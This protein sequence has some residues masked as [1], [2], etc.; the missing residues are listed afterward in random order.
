M[1]HSTKRIISTILV[2]GL[3]EPLIPPVIPPEWVYI[4]PMEWAPAEWPDQGVYELAEPEAI[5]P[6]RL[7]TLKQHRILN[8][9]I[10]LQARFEVLPGKGTVNDAVLAVVD[11]ALKQQEKQSG[12]RYTPQAHTVGAGLADR[13]CLQG[14]ST[15]PAE[16]LLNDP[17]L[18]PP[19]GVGTAVTCDVIAAYG[20]FFGQRLRTVV[21]DEDGIVSDTS[22]FIYVDLYTDEMFQPRDLWNESATTIVW[23]AVIELLRRQAGSLS[24]VPV[25]SQPDPEI[26]DA[27][28]AS[29]VLASDGSLTVTLPGGVTSAELQNL[30]LEPTEDP[31]TLALPPEV[32][33]AITTELGA[34]FVRAA[35]EALPFDGPPKQWAGTE[36][37]N[38]KLVPCVALTY[39]DGPSLNTPGLLDELAFRDVS[40]TFFVIGNRVQDLSDIVA[41]TAAEGH[42]VA[43]HS[44]S[45]PDLI[46]LKQKEVKKELTRTNDVIEEVTGVAPTIFRPPYGAVNDK[47]LKTAKMPAILWDVDTNDWKEDS[48]DALIEH[49]VTEPQ[50]GSIV[51]QHDVRNNTARTAG[52]VL[53]G[54]LDRGFE[55]VNLNQLFGGSL[56]T[57]GKIKSGRE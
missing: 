30:G 20:Q 9:K 51:L 33:E 4:S 31:I 25:V 53:D 21:A 41:R 12:A 36:S 19:N 2:L 15:M 56:P 7:E 29:T 48:D 46:D 22:T 42:I 38:C 16:S 10:G 34:E 52:P 37:V 14:S 3:L 1:K 17:T 35:S 44:W 8:D 43:N 27:A 24:L 26:V 5:D 45:H 55:I 50:P 28:L 6:L 18:A 49:A 39:D 47:I 23:T 11:Q 54:L 13:G 57:S 32:T 40:A